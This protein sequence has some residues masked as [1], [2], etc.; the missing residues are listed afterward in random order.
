LHLGACVHARVRGNA[1]IHTVYMRGRADE[2]A[3][4]EI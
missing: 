4:P 1:R 2:F 3:L